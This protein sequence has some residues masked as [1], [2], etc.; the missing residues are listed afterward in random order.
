[1]RIV[2][3]RL[4]IDALQPEDAE[5]L[6][7]YRADPAVA[8]YQGW[9]PASVAEAASFIEAQ[10][11]VAP[12]TAGEWWQRAIRLRDSGELIGDFGL[13]CVDTGTAELGITLA[14]A[15]QR[16]GY[17][18]DAVEVALDF[19]FGG[20]R[21]HRVVASVD[22]RN[23][24]CMRLLEGLGMHRRDEQA[25]D[26]RFELSAKEWLAAPTDDADSR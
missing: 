3:A 22:P 14:P 17:A 15:H 13:H 4:R 1:V 23:L 8:R 12:D 9:K 11:Q 5:T 6:F 7:A 20:L 2:T 24:A 26:V 10:L 18:R 19:A 16:R 21:K 25:G